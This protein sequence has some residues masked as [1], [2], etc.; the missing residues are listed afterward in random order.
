MSSAVCMSS[1]DVRRTCTA[2]RAC[3]PATHAC[4][5]THVDGRGTPRSHASTCMREVHELPDGRVLARASGAQHDAI[6]GIPTRTH[7][8]MHTHTRTCTHTHTHTHMHTH[9]HTCTCTHTHARGPHGDFI[10][11]FSVVEDDVRFVLQPPV[12][13]D[14]RRG[15]GIPHRH[16][17][18]MTNAGERQ[19]DRRHNARRNAGGARRDQQA[20]PARAP[21]REAR[22]RQQSVRCVHRSRTRPASGVNGLAATSA[23]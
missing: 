6:D 15:L 17:T 1:A 14:V 2:T 7:A 22:R 12:H 13:A 11:P 5:C 16:P 4:T 23:G 19:R 3:D 18:C 20:Q 8:L 10:I 9:T 21:T